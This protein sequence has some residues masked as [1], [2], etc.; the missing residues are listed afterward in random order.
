M[1]EASVEISRS[2]LLGLGLGVGERGGTGEEEGGDRGGGE[3]EGGGRGGGEA[4][5]GGV[6][7]GLGGQGFA[8]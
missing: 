6:L 4:E 2:E 8:R 3:E 1:V 5:G 7:I